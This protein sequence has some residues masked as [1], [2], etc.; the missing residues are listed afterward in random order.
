MTRTLIPRSDTTSAKTVEASDWE[1]YFENIVNDYIISGL[2]I[3][4]QCPGALAANISSGTARVIGL[5]LNNTT[6]CSISGLTA[7]ST[8]YIYL[9]VCRDACCEPS[10]WSFISNTTGVEDVDTMVI[11]TADTDCSTVTSVNQKSEDAW[12]GC[13]VLGL[14][15]SSGVSTGG[16][17]LFGS[18]IDG[19]VTITCNTTLTEIKF[20][21]NLTVNACKTLTT[22]FQPAL[23]YVR[24]L[25]TVNG[26]LEVNG[27][28]SSGG[29]GGVRSGGAGGG[30]VG[31]PGNPGGAGVA[32]S[33]GTAGTGG[34]AGGGGGASTGA[35]GGG[36]GNGGG[37]G[38]GGTGGPA[39]TASGGPAGAGGTISRTFYSVME[40]LSKDTRATAYGAG[41][42]GGASGSSGGGGGA[43]GPINP[44]GNNGSGGAGGASTGGAGGAGGGTLVLLAKNVVIGCGGSISANGNAGTIG[45]TAGPGASGNP[46]G[47]NNFNYGGGG[48]GGAGGGAGGGGG[49]GGGALIFVY[50]T[51]TNN[52]TLSVAGGT[53]GTGGPAAGG[54]AG[55]GGASGPLS[56]SPGNPGTAGGTAPGAGTTG[57][58]GSAGVLIQQKV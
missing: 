23:I 14:T 16:D 7:C 27:D 4:A 25:L 40:Y 10:G 26:T 44:P 17:F 29:A 41:G 36:G 12:C 18:G 1:L 47:G 32:G 53:G 35:I 54:S 21:N 46:W 49:G 48:G 56:P 24:N 39:G 3:S 57:S 19:N 15:Y 28:G 8:N 51:F 42:G 2:T 22:N 6:Q 20:Y 37:G 13:G 33:P 5:H 31:T 34:G 11:G 45:G 43:G 30:P 52:G 55:G 50:K 38:S 9:K 58:S